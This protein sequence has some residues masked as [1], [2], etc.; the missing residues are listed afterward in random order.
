MT[1]LIITRGLPGS[2]KSTWAKA[3]VA[4][5][6]EK[7]ARVNR[8]DL[9][10]LLYGRNAPL[11]WV[12]EEGITAAARPAII[13]L[14]KLDRSVVVDDMHLRMKYVREME[15]L[16]AEC[17]VEFEVNETFLDVSLETCLERDHLRSIRG[18]RSVT[19]AVI[20]DLHHKF[21]KNCERFIPRQ[22]ETYTYQIDHAL[23]PAW[24]VDLDGTLAHMNGRGPFEW[25]RVGE[26]TADD[27]VIALLQSISAANIDDILILSG[28]DGSCREQTVQWLGAHVV[29]FHRLFMREAG[30]TR[31]DSIIKLEIFR[32]L[33][34]PHYAVQGSIDDRN[35]VVNMWRRIGLT[36]FQVAEGDF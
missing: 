32:E 29:P 4:E 25:D 36:C 28:R 14:L 9:R 21:V 30:D 26:D 27:A 7:R 34:A 20:E 22:V 18:G 3:W 2:G 1:K 17:G 35:Q 16:A 31:K 12:L 6:P 5:D 15:E 24:L 23:P 10:Q 8:D 19:E 33:I 13:N 11:P